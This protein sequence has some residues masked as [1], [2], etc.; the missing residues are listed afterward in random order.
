[1]SAEFSGAEPAARV[2][3][4]HPIRGVAIGPADLQ[5]VIDVAAKYKAIPK[6]FA[7][8]DMICTCAI[9]K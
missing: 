9:R 2:K 7:A 5:P 3:M 4:H 6:G 1:M 8:A